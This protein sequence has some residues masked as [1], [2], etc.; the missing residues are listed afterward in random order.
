M[1]FIY[2]RFWIGESAFSGGVKEGKVG[3]G[4]LCRVM[5]FVCGVFEDDEEMLLFNSI[6]HALVEESDDHAAD[7]RQLA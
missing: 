1:C 2:L 7:V 3:E 4:E 5:L 6:G